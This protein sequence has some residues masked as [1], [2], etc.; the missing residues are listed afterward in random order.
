MLMTMVQCSG[1]N[2]VDRVLV[3]R[4]FP[5]AGHGVAQRDKAGYLGG[6]RALPR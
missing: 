2:V 3:D 4:L 5:F 6:D 1:R